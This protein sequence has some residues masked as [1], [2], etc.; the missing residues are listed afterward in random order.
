MK[1]TAVLLTAILALSAC[2]GVVEPPE[3]DPNNPNGTTASQTTAA[4]PS[5]P[6]SLITPSVNGYVLRYNDYDIVL[7]SLAED[8]LAALGEPMN[9]L[10]EE[11]CGFAG[12]DYQYFYSGVRFITFSP[13]VGEKDYILSITFEDD[14]VTTPE[15]VYIGMSRAEV[16]EIYGLPTEDGEVRKKY[17]KD[18]MSLSFIYDNGL[19]GDITYYFDAASEF[20][21]V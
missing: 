16:E 21:V 12:I 18:N 20:E 11:S 15:G 5:T 8:L 10:S 19:V 3:V 14:I 1:K 17:L 9:T 4:T 7:G 6:T 13:A 2:N